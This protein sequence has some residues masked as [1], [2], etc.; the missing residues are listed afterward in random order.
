V[1][2]ETWGAG[3]GTP[4]PDGYRKAGWLIADE[5]LRFWYKAY[6]FLFRNILLFAII[7]D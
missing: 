1:I 6:T 4:I 3:V 7:G 2:L 5:V